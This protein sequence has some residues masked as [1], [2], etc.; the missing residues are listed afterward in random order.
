LRVTVS[1]FNKRQELLLVLAHWR[2]VVAL[3]RCV[4]SKTKS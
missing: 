1:K 2:V 3:T 4:S